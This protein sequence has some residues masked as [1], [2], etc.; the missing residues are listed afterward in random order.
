MQH[1]SLSFAARRAFSLMELAIVL[2]I[3]GLLVG[4]IMVGESLLAGQRLRT[5]TADAAKYTIAM[6]QFQQKY[7]YL[8]GDFPTATT[9]WGRADAGTPITSN[10]AAPDTNA[11]SGI[12]TCNGDGDGNLD[13]VTN[14]ETYRAWQHMMAAGLIAGQYTGVSSGV[15]PTYVTLGGNVPQGALDAT[16]YAWLPGPNVV[17]SLLAADTTYFDGDY[18]NAL[19]FG[20]SSTT[21]SPGSGMGSPALTPTEMKEIDM[22]SDD[23]L[24]AT[25]GIRSW[26]STSTLA[27]N[28]TSSTSYNTTNTTI[29]C[30][31]IFLLGYKV[32][33][34]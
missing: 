22:K 15:A 24:P 31:P 7:G 23:A 27:P 10:C 3:L 19:I 8:A 6:T 33:K 32:Q 26:R 29:A 21:A 2:V 9:I 34:Q 4:G 20:K 1:L 5:I 12:A 11:S 16:G 14:H 17:N 28:C 13:A 18:S 25:G 30:A